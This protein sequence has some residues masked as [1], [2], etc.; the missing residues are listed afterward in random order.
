M[1][2]RYIPKQGMARNG[3]KPLA[4]V[5][6]PMSLSHKVLQFPTHCRE[7]RQSLSYWFRLGFLPK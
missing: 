4:R 6:P 7:L 3:A 5:I 1:T 2:T